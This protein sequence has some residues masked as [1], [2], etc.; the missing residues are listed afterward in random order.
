MAPYAFSW[1]NVAAG[2]YSITA[3]AYDNLN[4]VTTSAAVAITVQTAVASAGTLYFIHPDHLDT[5]RQVSDATGKVVWQWE[6]QEPFGQIAPLEDPDADAKAFVLNLRFAGQYFDAESRLHYNVQRDYDPATG[7]YV[8]ADPIGLGGGISLYGYVGGNPLGFVDPLGLARCRL[9]AADMRA[10]GN[11]DSSLKNPHRHHIVME[12]APRNWK[13]AARQDVF[14]AQKILSDNGIGLNNDRRNFSWASN[15]GHSYDYASKVVSRLR[16]GQAAN[17]QQGV[18]DALS[19]M[20]EILA[21]GSK[22]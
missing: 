2:S 17:G 6:E 14:D 10:M 22:L 21:S 18:V 9:S 8:Q 5:S 19:A 20:K 1:T 16:A 3:R 11:P 13:Q 4:A 12:N 15:E 7:R